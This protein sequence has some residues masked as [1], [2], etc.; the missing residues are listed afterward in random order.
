MSSEASPAIS[1]PTP[2][3]IDNVTPDDEQAGPLEAALDLL[4][5]LPPHRIEENLNSL[6]KLLP[7]YADTLRSTV[8]VPAKVCVCR[9][10]SR[11]YLICEYNRDGDSYRSPWSNEYEPPLPEGTEG[12]RL[13]T[14][15]R[16]LEL[17]A[18]EAF[19][20]YRM[21]YYD[22]GISSVYVWQVPPPPNLGEQSILESF[23]MAILI[24]KLVKEAEEEGINDAAWDS[25]HVVEVTVTMP[26]NIS[27]T[28]N[29]AAT[30]TARRQAHYK[31]TTTI[32]VH[33]DSEEERL[34]N[35]ILSGNVTRQIEHHA[36]LPTDSIEEHI[37]QI[38]RLI[39]DMESRMRSSL[40]EIY[41]GKTLD[42]INEMRP[43]MPPGYLR[44][45]ADLQH[46]MQSRL[47]SSGGGVRVLPFHPGIAISLKSKAAPGGSEDSPTTPIPPPQEN[48]PSDPTPSQ[49]DNTNG[50]S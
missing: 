4:R 35:F 44:N 27:E 38:G 23:M 36:A 40:Q 16:Q 21:L 50:E 18:N 29:S 41:F 30:T 26:H 9:K 13:S 39:E 5:R 2:N 49:V 12:L 22:G 47:A 28:S 37:P 43:M 7:Q 42:M 31:L 3:T 11:E 17:A 8:D 45:Q 48:N 10:T 46:E 14:Q 6:I 1:L 33:L 19:T 25:M 15:L 20:T 24:K 34:D 32:T